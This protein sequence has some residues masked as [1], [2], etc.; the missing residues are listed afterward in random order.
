MD[1]RRI[2]R[3]IIIFAGMLLGLGV[4]VAR[5]ADQSGRRPAL[6]AAAPPAAAASAAAPSAP[7]QQDSYGSSVTVP[8]DARGHF[9]VDA[10]VDG[11]HMGF[12]IDTGASM[13][14]IRANDAALLGVHPVA[15][16]FTVA[17]QTANGANRAAPVQLGMVEV[18][19][20]S[21]RNVAALVMPDAALG[22][23]LLG[24]SFLSRLRRFEYSNGKMVLEQ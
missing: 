17:V 14:A 20:V 6:A 9:V 8:R 2:M 21:V 4:V 7:A 19:G 5:I 3:S 16:D 10:R 13:I 18:S 1:G 15:R 24:L 23:N 12:M 11:R 22:E